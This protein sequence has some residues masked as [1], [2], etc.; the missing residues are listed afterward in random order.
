MQFSELNLSQPIL[1]ALAHEGYTTPTPIQQQAIPHAL[2]GSDVLGSAQTGTGKTAAFAIPILQRLGAAAM[3]KSKR[4]PQRCRAL[5][6]SPTRELAGQI[7]DS[8]AAYGR[9]TGLTHTVIYGGVSQ[10]HQERAL[11]RGID[12]IV[13]TPGRLLDLMQ[14]RLVDLSGVEVLVLDEADRMLD[15]GFIDP[16]RRIAAATPS[17]EKGR[18]TLLFSATMPRPIVQLANSLL[19]DP[20]RI[21]VDPVS[22]TAGRIEQA[23]Y[24][25]TT[26]GKQALLESLL[27]D[28][29]VERALVFSRTKHGAER[30]GRRL[31]RAGIATATIHGNKNQNQRQRALNQFRMTCSRRARV[32]VAT[33]V[34]ARG[35]DVDGI[36]HVFNFDLPMEAEAYVHRIGRT[37]RAGAAGIALSFCAPDERSMLR[38]IERLTGKSIQMRTADNVPAAATEERPSQPRR[39]HT[40]PR[41][42]PAAKAN[43]ADARTNQAPRSAKPRHWK[44]QPRSGRSVARS[45]TRHHA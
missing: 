40:P 35:L 16:I 8:F 27:A 24:M 34:A 38:Q 11:R 33:D 42:A 19:K 7:A 2:A 5:V 18:Q 44:G 3:D 14:Q 12:I 22:S 10:V 43:G 25:V 39:E 32:L 1:R 15:M 9:E 17:R 26:S 36:T 41:K 45:G 23:A 37:G 13:A 28:P 6:L 20:V 30:I 4:G 29:T 21:A 31:E